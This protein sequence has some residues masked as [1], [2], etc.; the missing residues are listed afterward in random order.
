MKYIKALDADKGE[1]FQ[2]FQ[3][4]AEA[5]PTTSPSYWAQERWAEIGPRLGYLIDRLPRPSRDGTPL[6]RLLDHGFIARRAGDGRH[7]LFGDP[8]SVTRA[9]VAP[10]EARYGLHICIYPGIWAPGRTFL[11]E[12]NVLDPRRAAHM[13]DTKH[14]NGP[15]VVGKPAKFLGISLSSI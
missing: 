4:P 10:I 7:V 14:F 3:V 15:L 12:M 13:F 8:Y 11:L 5:L 1:P 2:P 9:D 6:G